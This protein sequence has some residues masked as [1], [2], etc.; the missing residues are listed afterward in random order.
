MF[1]LFLIL[2][3]C[4]LNQFQLFPLN[5]SWH[6]YLVNEENYEHC[7]YWQ[8]KSST[9]TDGDK[10][11][12]THSYYFFCYLLLFGLPLTLQ[13]FDAVGWAAGRASGL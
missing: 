3:L 13:C 6:A 2:I 4:L 12:D 1:K 9:N 8:C 11:V 10:S 7:V 5:I